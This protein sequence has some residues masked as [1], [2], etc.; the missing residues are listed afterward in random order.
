MQ[1]L[2]LVWYRHNNSEDEGQ[3]EHRGEESERGFMATSINIL[4]DGNMDMGMDNMYMY[5]SP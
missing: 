1:S 4:S 2:R 3:D 5:T